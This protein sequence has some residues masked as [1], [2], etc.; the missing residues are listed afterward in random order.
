MAPAL[1]RQRQN[2]DPWRGAK[3][4][5]KQDSKPVAETRSVTGPVEA[6][7]QQQDQRLAAL[8]QGMSDLRAE[9]AKAHEEDR[10]QQ[11]AQHTALE[12]QVAGLA[13]QF[14]EQL[15][16]SM[17]LVQDAQLRQQEQMQTAMDELKT[18]IVAQPAP[19]RKARRE[20]SDL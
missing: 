17:Q 6:R 5:G 19:A 14:S 9:H 10:Q 18:L 3:L 1:T 15:K 7:F 11:A 20:E 16:A 4:P 2:F 12:G 8:E 13:R